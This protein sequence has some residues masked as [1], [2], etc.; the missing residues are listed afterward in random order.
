MIFGILNVIQSYGLNQ[1]MLDS[2]GIRN[3]SSSLSSRML[4]ATDRKLHLRSGSPK[5]EMK[6]HRQQPLNGKDMHPEQ[7]LYKTGPWYIV[8]VALVCSNIYIS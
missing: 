1:A 8:N 6:R 3:Y 2:V 5:T 7:G 4:E